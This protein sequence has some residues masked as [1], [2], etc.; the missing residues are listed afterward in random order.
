M[1]VVSNFPV[2]HGHKF[3]K[4]AIK[5]KRVYFGSIEIVELAMI[6]G[7]HPAC[8]NG[9]PVQTSWNAQ[10][11]VSVNLDEYELTRTPRRSIQ[12]LRLSSAARSIM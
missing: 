10:S 8:R 5:Q 7:D 11:R 9:P 12:E 2:F 1:A 4:M 3:N 6:L